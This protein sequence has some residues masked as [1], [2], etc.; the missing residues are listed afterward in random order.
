MAAE[1]VEDRAALKS[2]VSRLGVAPSMSKMWL[3]WLGERAGRLKPHGRSPLSRVIELELMRLGVEGK[4]AC[5]RSLEV[6]AEH[7]PRLPSEELTRLVRRSTA[8]IKTLRLRAATE[9]SSSVSRANGVRR[10]CPR[11]S[12]GVW[13]GC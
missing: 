8:Q 1:V 10:G 3:S 2:L 11:P 7:E 12:R 6:V 9:A 13:T 4:L 5:W